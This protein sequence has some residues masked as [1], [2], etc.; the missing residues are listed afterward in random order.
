MLK[1]QGF[2]WVAPENFSLSDFRSEG[3][4]GPTVCMTQE[5]DYLDTSNWIDLIHAHQQSLWGNWTA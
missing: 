2:Q 1:L 3:H 5:L 4:Y